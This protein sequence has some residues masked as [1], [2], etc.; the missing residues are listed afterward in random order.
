MWIYLL[1]M[2]ILMLSQVTLAQDLSITRLEYEIQQLKND[3]R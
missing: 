2:D 3:V 1:L